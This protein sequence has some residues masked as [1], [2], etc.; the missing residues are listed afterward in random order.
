MLPN[1]RVRYPHPV[2]FE[3]LAAYDP[4]RAGHATANERF[5][6]RFGWLGVVAFGAFCIMSL[7]QWAM[8]SLPM[9]QDLI[10]QLRQQFR[11]PAQQRFFLAH[12]N[13]VLPI[14]AAVMGIGAVASLKLLRRRNWARWTL[15]VV[16][17]C[18]AAMGI[19]S[20][21]FVVAD[22]SSLGFVG[23]KIPLF[24]IFMR[25][26]NG[27]AIVFNLAIAGGL[28]WLVKRLSSSEVKE[29]CV[30]GGP[31]REGRFPGLM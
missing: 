25:V 23:P 10:E 24:Q 6:N 5:V 17:S 7:A 2:G 29:Q 14:Q 1:V 22:F 18:L 15:M 31:H 13:Y 16:L 9:Y 27:A 30:E 19:V 28:L 4:A 12:L 3:G 11:L 8:L 20:T 26:V 21:V